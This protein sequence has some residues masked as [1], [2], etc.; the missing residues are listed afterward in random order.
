M[1]NTS[2]AF[3]FVHGAWH[4]AATWRLIRPLLEARGHVVR[5][6]DLPGAGRNAKTP[7]SYG[8]RPL[9]LAAFATEPSPNADVSQEDRTHAGV[10]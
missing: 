5:E 9:D 1:S 3:V 10:L 2:P 7:R 6:L 8:R 4:D